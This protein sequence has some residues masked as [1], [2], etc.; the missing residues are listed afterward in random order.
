MP[1]H[2]FPDN[3][4]SMRQ[5]LRFTF[6][7]L[8][9]AIT[10]VSFPTFATAESGTWNQW[11]GPNRDAV[12]TEASLPNSLADLE[13]A[14]EVPLGPSYSGPVVWES[15]VITTETV[16][17]QF[18]RLLAFDMASGEKR[19]SVD[20]G[21]A[22]AVP[23]FAAA[24][25]SWIRS[26]PAV[27]PGTAEASPIVVALGMRDQI[28]AADPTSGAKLWERDLSETLGSPRPA[29]GGVCS[30]LIDETGIYV[31]TG[32]PLVKLDR[33]DGSAVWQTDAAAGGG[34][35]M[36]SGAFSSPVMATI[37]GVRQLVVQSRTDLYGVD[38]ETGTRLWSQPIEAF[39]GMNILTPTVI[40]DRV[41]T[42]AHSGRSEMFA[43][44]R[45]ADGGWTVTQQWEN[46]TQAYMSSPTVFGD[47]LFMHAK[48]ERWVLLDADSGDTV[49]TG[50][51]MGKY[52]SMIRSD[53]RLLSLDNTGTLRLVT[54]DSSATDAPVQVLDERSVA[55]DSWAHLG[56]EAK[57]LLV[58]D[59]KALKVFRW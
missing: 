47:R 46:P 35:M 51:P 54:L 16:D 18:E 7:A 36:S 50:R 26:T 57:N 9:A 53:D 48:N 44:S 42:A 19:W 5:S 12:V 4:Q 23:F 37:Q 27:A 41:F 10:L 32:G 1:P 38:P 24:N 13:L 17:D 40:G 49:W 25:G 14:W 8:A 15:S 58:R 21:G 29:F 45:A 43:I 52:Q 20:F 2:L 55:E 3:R 31:Q 6:S 39:R 28:V 34:N 11:R 56:I 22:M 30:P 59:L 33:G